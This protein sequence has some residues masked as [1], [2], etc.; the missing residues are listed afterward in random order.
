MKLDL[1]NVDDFV[2]LNHLKEITNPGLMPRAGAPHPEGLLSEDIF[3]VTPKSRKNTFAYIDLHGH[4]FAP[5]VY[6]I[7]RALFRNI[8]SI[9]NG[10]EYYSVKDGKLVKDPKGETGIDFVYKNWKKIK[11]EKSEKE[12]IRNQRVDVLSRLPIEEAFWSKCPVIPVFYRDT[13]TTKSGGDVNDLNNLYTRLIRFGIMI[14]GRD[15]FDFSFHQTN[16]NIQNTLVLIYDYFKGRLEKK[17]GMIRKYLMGKSVDYSTRTVITAP[18]FDADRPD[19]LITSIVYAGVP[20]H[21]IC[22]LCYPFVLKWLK[23]FFERNVVDSGAI[24]KISNVSNG[25]ATINR[26]LR[27][28][29][30]ELTYTDTYF[31][32]A[33]DSFI[34]DPSSRFD[35][36]PLKLNDGSEMYLSI[37]Y[38]QH[39][40]LKPVDLKLLSVLLHGQTFYI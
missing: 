15:M 19:K 10:T 31:K 4:F 7:V 34:K 30:P 26:D 23:D 28:D 32:K 35:L 40:I 27:V 5:H 37:H 24:A 25:T 18:R 38:I 2:E 8:D 20:I 6:K 39:L 33:I 13:N 16:M 14:A 1:M 21:Q 29:R 12:G 17:T 22:S 11:W 3:G 36:I 9:I